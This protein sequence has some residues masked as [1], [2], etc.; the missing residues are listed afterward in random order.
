MEVVPVPIAALA[1]E[2]KEKSK[3]IANP[4][5]IALEPTIKWRREVL[6]VVIFLVMIAPYALLTA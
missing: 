6:V 5:A 2:M 3:P 1:D 4:V